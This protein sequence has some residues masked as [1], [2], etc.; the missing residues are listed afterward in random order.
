MPPF[1]WLV[2]L[3]RRGAAIGDT[4]TVWCFVDFLCAKSN[5]AAFTA[6]SRTQV[7]DGA[8]R[9]LDAAAAARI[10][11]SLFRIW[12]AF[13]LSSFYFRIC[14][15]RVALD[16]QTNFGFPQEPGLGL[17]FSSTDTLHPNTSGA[18]LDPRTQSMGSR[19]RCLLRNPRPIFY[20][21]KV[22]S[23]YVYVSSSQAFS[24]SVRWWSNIETLF[25]IP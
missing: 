14:T 6:L 11:G 12:P 4:A 10:L 13:S 2:F 7:C 17:A 5:Q 22:I 19:W 18:A 24:Q 23:T 21:V 1:F 3:P 15:R 8:R 9:G 25:F 20:F 16:P